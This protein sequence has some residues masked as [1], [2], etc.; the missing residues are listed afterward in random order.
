MLVAD[1]ILLPD[2]ESHGGRS[3]V[4]GLVGALLASRRGSSDPMYVTALFVREGGGFRRLDPDDG[5][6]DEAARLIQERPEDAALFQLMKSAGRVGLWAPT[7]L[8]TVLRL[9]SDIGSSFTREEAGA[10]RT[11]F[12]G[13]QSGSFDA[14]SGFDL[15]TKEVVITRTPLW[16]G[17]GHNLL[18]LVV[19]GAFAYSLGWIPE[20][21]ARRRRCALAAGRCPRCGYA[22]TGLPGAR[23]PECGE[24]LGVSRPG[25]G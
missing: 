13:E 12:I 21:K 1:V 3:V 16:R 6:W 23:C 19:F 25:S 15:L 4:G 22:I 5:S 24:A 10:L 8:R 14:T 7:A 18:A 17:Y 20:I 9:T 2:A 11:R